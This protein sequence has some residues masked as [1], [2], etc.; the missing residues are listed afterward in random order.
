[1]N[2]L[3]SAHA[4]KEFDAIKNKKKKAKIK[5]AIY[6]LPSG[7]LKKLKG[8]F[9][10]YWRLRVGEYRVIFSIEESSIIII[11]IGNRKDVY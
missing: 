10:N 11:G 1:M 7:D 4:K 2:I 9:K 8:K 5:E 3:W 6:F